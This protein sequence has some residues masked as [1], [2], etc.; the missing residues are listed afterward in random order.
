MRTNNQH[1]GFAEMQSL[2]LCSQPNGNA[3]RAVCDDYEEILTPESR[4]GTE[5]VLRALY[6]HR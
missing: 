2:L 3:L 6:L 1:K 4:Q 5:S